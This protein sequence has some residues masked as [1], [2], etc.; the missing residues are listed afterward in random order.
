MLSMGLFWGIHIG[1]AKRE[2]LTEEEWRSAVLRQ[3][4]SGAVSEEIVELMARADTVDR[5]CSFF[6][7]QGAGS[8]LFRLIKAAKDSALEGAAEL[9]LDHEMRLRHVFEKTGLS[10]TAIDE[11]I[12]A[13]AKQRQNIL[14]QSPQRSQAAPEPV[15][16]AENSGDSRAVQV[17]YGDITSRSLM[18]SALGRLETRSRS[19]PEDTLVKTPGGGVAF[20][21]AAKAGGLRIIL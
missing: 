13:L 4:E 16:T 2:E 8:F 20:A 5:P 3:I 14:A 12:S 21:L 6:P 9:Y 17:V 19:H 18:G 11:H 15:W 10:S 1:S 7:V